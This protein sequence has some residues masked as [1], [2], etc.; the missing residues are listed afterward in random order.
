M[1]NNCI[2]NIGISL[3]K[4]KKKSDCLKW[5]ITSPNQVGSDKQECWLGLGKRARVRTSRERKT[6]FI[7][8]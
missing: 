5:A 4:K 1:V 8:S 7:V 6:G 2:R 3:K